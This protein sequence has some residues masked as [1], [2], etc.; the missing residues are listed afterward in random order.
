MAQTPRG[1][2]YEPPCKG[3]L[4]VCAIY[5]ETTVIPQRCKPNSKWL[6]TGSCTPDSVREKH[7]QD[8][9]DLG[10]QEGQTR[11]L[12]AIIGIDIIIDRKV[13]RSNEIIF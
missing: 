6:Q 3:H 1:G 4:E 10:T 11:G 12:I 7:Q 9:K 2:L 8:H 13:P 5:S